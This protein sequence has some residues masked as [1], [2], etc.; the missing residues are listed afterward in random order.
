MN[1]K[2]LFILTALI[3]VVCLAFSLFAAAC[4]N[5]ETT[6]TDN[7]ETDL[8]FT[9]GTFKLTSDTAVLS[10]PNNWT[11]A[12]GSTSSSNATPSDDDDLTKGVVDSS[13]A[14]WKNLK[15]EYKTISISSPGRGKTSE[16]NENLDDNKILMIH[17]MVPTA[18]KYT[19]GSTTI[20][21]NSYYKLSVDVKT[22]LDDD[23]TDPLA[24]AYIYVNGSAYA[25]WTAIDTNGEWKTYTLYI[26]GSQLADGTITVALS[27][28]VGNTDTGH[29][30]KGYAFFDNVYLENLSE[31]DED[32]ENDKPFTKEMYDDIEITSEVS[33]YTMTTADG[34]FDYVTS[35]IS[36]PPYSASKYTMVSGFG[37]GNTASTSSTYVSKGILDTSTVKDYKS[38]LSALENLL[39]SQGS[40]IDE[41]A[42]PEV[43][44]GTRMLYMQ[45]KQ[46][47]A[48]GM[49]PSVGMNF[50][51]NTFY[52]V[53]VWA[54]SYI[55][56]GPASIRLTNGTNDD[57]NNY[58]IDNISTNGE[59][60][61]YSFYVAANQFRSSELY[62]EFW[63]GYGGSNDTDTHA[64][65]AIFFDHITLEEVKESDYSSATE[66]DSVKKI[67]LQTDE[68]NMTS[69]NLADF[70][71]L[72]SED[73]IKDRSVFEVI[74]TENFT[75]GE[76]FKT[77]PGKPVD[78]DSDI[79]NSKVL[80]INNY[81]PSA[82]TLSNLYYNGTST[83]DKTISIAPN[84][85]YAISMF[86]KTENV[87]S[88]S[89]LNIEL[90]K[91]NKDY[92]QSTQKFE[93]A[94][95]SLTSFTNINTV[96]LEDYKGV[97]DYTL[98]TFYVVG[99]ELEYANLAVA[100]SLGTGTGSDYSTLTSGYA[101]ISS[102]Y[103]EEITYSEYA[104]VTTATNIKTYS[105]TSSAESSEVS[106]NG[107]FK[108]VDI[109]S[110][111]NIYGTDAFGKDGMLNGFL[112]A[113]TNWSVNNTTVLND[114]SYKNM[115]GVLNLN[116]ESQLN[117]LG[118]IKDGF[119]TGIED[120]VT[121]DGKNVN[122]T[123][124]AIKKDDSIA[125]LGYTSNSISLS[126]K[127]Y[128][129][130]NVWA[131]APEGSPFSIILKTATADDN[132]KLA[133]LVGDGKWHMYTVFVETGISSTSVTL[134]LNAGYE[135]GAMTSSTV[136][137]TG[138][139][140]TTVSEKAFENAQASTSSDLLAQSWLV[141]SFD[142][143]KD[144]ED[145]SAPNNF[146][147]ALIDSDAS[148]DEDTLVSGVINKTK[149]DFSK[150]DLDPDN[151]SDEAIINS[152][153]NDENTIVGD[154]VLVIYN[155]D[156]TAYG[157]TSNSA[158]IEAGKYYKISIWLLTYK[159]AVNAD[160]DNLDDAF[161]PTATI[162][163]K[164][165][166][167]TY[168]FGKKLTS[169]SENYDKQRIINTSTYDEEGNE[170]IGKWTE[171]SFYIYAEEDIES[172]TATLTVSLGFD[173]EDYN[174]TGYVFVDNFSVEE[175]E[176]SEFIARQD[177][178]VEDA[179]GTYYKDGDKY[180]EVSESNPAPEGAT[181]Y[182]KLNDAEVADY[183]NSLNS[184]LL[185]ENSVKNNYRIVF[186]SDDSTEE[187]EEEE[188][189]TEEP[190][191]DPFV[192]L[193]VVSGVVSG[194][195]VIIIVIILIKKFAPKRKKK[196]VK[197]TKKPVSAPKSG[198]KRDQ[199][200][201]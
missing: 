133:T 36:A 95:T 171:Y 76:F 23:N 162:T 131:K 99:E 178:Y 97:N 53:S 75:A 52:K 105:L 142:D 135:S 54:K 1:K 19:S 198:D 100:F 15:K 62:L 41:L 107:Y 33:K 138:V 34:E 47:T 81:K 117:A 42:V 38:S 169:S 43:S 145:L 44:V 59:W 165:N 84:K 26:E 24:G 144:A 2:R 27:L 72:N 5:D 29:L 157:Y 181:L 30:T 174:L 12:P 48:F 56:S 3:L 63:L 120:V 64:V 173:G 191:K 164:A 176:E 114:S 118:I 143:V 134:S 109:S 168:Q 186:T 110:T 136:F 66:S 74:D 121:L 147:G 102:L 152:I 184:V 175:I 4:D 146:T 104:S 183:D 188:P 119:Y 113:P 197:G 50:N 20:N 11:G 73:A 8:L 172:T 192:W 13:S 9:N 137:F 193:Y 55:T 61:E 177:V 161:V 65:G 150:I 160:A 154:K 185:D 51:S 194:L 127:S 78:F 116:N 200:G 82:T 94:Y 149:T 96:N 87:A 45:N 58:V 49:R 199:F 182:K 115:A 70:G 141:D 16:T 108:Y 32:D 77:N 151:E 28:G 190:E 18:Y 166:N 67:N 88:A 37:S 91:Y 69:V 46:A 129:A 31:V 68:E 128:Y 39:T 155:K 148:S 10:S 89:G 158:D 179:E 112:G 189:T 71:I 163:L 98:F 132:S 7:T 40:S 101:Y 125:T 170:T 14:A 111:E 22:L 167:K 79:F 25:G 139:T 90:L 86:V 122:P 103:V 126:A 92:D 187:P 60:K 85:V 17:N 130:F 123:V 57:S 21:K 156:N 106:S 196:L 6:P 80:A 93:K 159:L 201:K 180:V 140:Y 153:F 83:V 35:V 195:I 124:L